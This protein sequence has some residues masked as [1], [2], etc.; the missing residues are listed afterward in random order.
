VDLALDLFASQNPEVHRMPQPPFKVDPSPTD[1]EPGSILPAWIQEGEPKTRSKNVVRS[2]DW[3][4]HLVVWECTA[5]RFTWKYTSDET[6]VVVSGEAFVSMG[7]GEEFRLGPGDIGYFPAGTTCTWRVPES[8]RKV[9]VL[10]ETTWRPV[11]FC[12]KVFNKLLRV[13]GLKGESAL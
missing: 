6:L 8:V 1:L 13:L 9:A 12:L 11:G 2:H 10:H 3:L 4:E 5:G 7:R